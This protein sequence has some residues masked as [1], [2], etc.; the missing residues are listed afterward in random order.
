[1][2]RERK[3]NIVLLCGLCIVLLL[4]IIFVPSYG[5]RLRQFFF[6]SNTISSDDQNVAAENETLKAELAQVQVLQ[7]EM[8]TS[9]PSA[10]RAMVYSRY[11]FNFKNELTVNAGS[12]QG[13]A[14]GSAVFFQEMLVGQV[15]SVWPNTALVQTIFDNN[16]K[17]PVRIGA[18]GYDGFLQGSPYPT[19]GSIAKNLAIKPGDIV[20]AA[21]VG[22]PYGLPIGE[23]S[24]TSTSA[25]SL[26]QQASLNFTYDI[27][28]IQTV[29]I[30]KQ[31]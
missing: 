2:T 9:S 13:V 15:Q 11:P 7:S 1:M 27:N 19:V 18:K 21:G 17:L 10:I 23:V 28:N 20:Y 30:Q 14:S 12:D 3:S 31:Q 25:D 29:V 16:F 8:P 24:A 26:F 6:A 4:F 5:W 22:F